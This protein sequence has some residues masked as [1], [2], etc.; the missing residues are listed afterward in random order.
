MNFP[1]PEGWQIPTGVPSEALTKIQH[2]FMQGWQQ[3]SQ[4]A[5]TGH[6]PPIKDRRFAAPA[7][8]SS[9]AHLMMAHLYL[10]SANAMGKMV[11]A[12][13]AAPEVK[14]RLQ[15]SVMQ[16][17]DALS[18]ANFFATNPD[19]QAALV[20]SGGESLVA[21]LKNLLSDVQRGRISQTDETKFQ[22]GENVAT[23]AGAVVFQNRFFQLLQYTPTTTTVFQ[24][25]ILLVPPCIN[26]FYILDLQPENSFVRHAVEQGF[27]VFLMSWRNPLEEDQDGIDCATWDDYLEEGVL[28]AIEVTREISGQKQINALGFC[29]GGTILATALA[30]AAARGEQPV[31]ALTMLTSM[32]DFKDTGALGVFVDEQH[33]KLREQQIGQGGLMSARELG[34]TFS[35]LRPNELVWNYVVSNYLKGET[36]AAFDLLFW[37]GDSTN[38]PGPF[39]T[40]YFRNTYL[41]NK[42]RAPN[43]L[44]CCGERIDLRKLNMPTYL[45]ASRE[46]HIVPWRSAFSSMSLFSGD[47]RFVLGASGHIAGVI[48]PPAK[49]K[50]NYWVGSDKSSH[51]DPVKWEA[52]ATEVAGSW[53]PD[54]YEWLAAQSGKKVKA[55]KSL[56]NT[57]NKVIE[58]APGS[59]VKV[60]AV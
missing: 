5:A 31:S 56:G 9:P 15:F 57:K 33:A 37:N 3:L 41:E 52:Q 45:Y 10:L 1:F 36:P 19:A 53:W 50:R 20:D 25:P 60:R 46:D 11:E 8:A 24:R 39:F 40:W 17:V 7:W 32:V 35:F 29:V 2:D 30:V 28:K 18:P 26:K 16:W 42:L 49:K 22:V 34:A 27:T 54:W 48:N 43:K 21:G 47:N 14:D 38:L 13:D 58:A 12:S 55:S 44:T 51:T 59:Y 4:E 23:T 6:L